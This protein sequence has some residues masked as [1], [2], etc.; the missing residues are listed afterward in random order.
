MDNEGL[1][2]DSLKILIRKFVAERDWAQFHRPTSLAISAA[3][4]MGE[5]L[6][7]FQW[8]TEEEIKELLK[9]EEFRTNLADEIADVLVYI[10][11]LADVTGINPAKAVLRKMKQ[12]ESKYPAEKWRGRIPDKVR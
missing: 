10:L 11:R 6:E 5:L 9:D 7:L 8:R 1:T 2:L 12:N 3:V 4:E